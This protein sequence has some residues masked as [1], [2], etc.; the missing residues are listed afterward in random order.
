MSEAEV[1]WNEAADDLKTELWEWAEH[2][3]LRQRKWILELANQDISSRKALEKRAKYDDLWN[4]L[5]AAVSGGLRGELRDWF[6]RTYP[7]SKASLFQVE[8]LPRVSRSSAFCSQTSQG[9]RRTRN[10][11]MVPDRSPE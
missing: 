8:N 1:S 9:I 4:E 11:R 5:C 2:N 10:E 3:T 6:T 7:D